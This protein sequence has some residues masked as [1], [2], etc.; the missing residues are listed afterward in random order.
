MEKGKSI[1]ERGKVRLSEYFKKINNGDTVAIVTEDSI[2]SNYSYRVIGLTG[3]VI[4]ERGMC[5]II[6]IMHGNKKKTIII[7]PIHLKVLNAKKKE[8]KAKVKVKEKVK[9]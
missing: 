1:R 5:K 9:K 7:H 3:K 6:Q 4:G 2:P 8:E